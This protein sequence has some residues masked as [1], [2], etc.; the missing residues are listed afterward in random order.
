MYVYRMCSGI[1]SQSRT[2]IHKL[3]QAIGTLTAASPGVEHAPLYIR[4]MEIENNKQLRI[5]NGNFGFMPLTS[6]IKPCLTWWIENAN[7]CTK[8][9]SLRVANAVMYTDASNLMW[10]AYDETHNEKTN[11][12]W[13][14][15]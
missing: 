5:H 9:V 15:Q 7:E 1:F 4:P 14:T 3:S 12:F 8:H 6:E 11:G 2:T 10:G 13:S